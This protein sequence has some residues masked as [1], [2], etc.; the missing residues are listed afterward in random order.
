MVFTITRQCVRV[1]HNEIKEQ[2]TKMS[3]GLS[4]GRKIE[5]PT[6]EKASYATMTKKQRR[7]LREYADA[8]KGMTS[9]EITEFNHQRHGF[10]TI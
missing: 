5:K 9:E 7:E 10:T 8:T 1:N 4:I 6:T 3:R 2:G